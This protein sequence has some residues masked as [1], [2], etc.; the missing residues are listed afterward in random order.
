MSG[1]NDGSD[2][3]ED[4]SGAHESAMKRPTAFE[5]VRSAIS[6]FLGDHWGFPSFGWWMGASQA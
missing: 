4:L 2:D 6:D 5:L 3:H 1:G